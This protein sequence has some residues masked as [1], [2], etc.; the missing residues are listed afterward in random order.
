[1]KKRGISL[2]VLVITIIVMIILAA[3]IIISLNNTGIVDNANKAR[4]E[5]NE[6]TIVEL[7]NLAWGEAYANSRTTGK[8]VS[9]NYFQK[10]VEDAL[11][12]NGVDLKEYDVIA[13]EDGVQV[14][15]KDDW[16]SDF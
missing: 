12:Q 16:S 11:T 2:I 7:A 6:K 9:S 1:M 14:F 4:D 8:I 15:K 13:G 5:T 10:S 3:A